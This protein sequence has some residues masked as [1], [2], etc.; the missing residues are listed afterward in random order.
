MTDVDAERRFLHTGCH[1]E[2]DEHNP[3]RD[4][5]VGVHASTSACAPITL[6]PAEGFL[7]PHLDHQRRTP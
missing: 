6:R 1:D 2:L 5:Y 4:Y 3:H 7:M